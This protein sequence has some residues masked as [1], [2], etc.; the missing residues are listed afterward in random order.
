MPTVVADITDKLAKLVERTRQNRVRWKT[1]ADDDAFGAVVGNVSVIISSVQVD[2]YAYA[3]MLKIVNK[4]GIDIEE[5]SGESRVEPF[6]EV[7]WDL[8]RMARRVALGVDSQLDEL[9]AEL[10][11]EDDEAVPG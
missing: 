6:Q 1:T 8:Y 5:L 2:Q 4:D 9:L 3:P 7:M 11:K 10:D